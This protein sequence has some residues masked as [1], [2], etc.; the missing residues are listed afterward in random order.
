MCGWS[1]DNSYWGLPSC[2]VAFLDMFWTSL[3]FCLHSK[4]YI[5]LSAYG[6]CLLSSLRLFDG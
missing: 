5:L 6:M 2:A 1:C 4:L 3:L